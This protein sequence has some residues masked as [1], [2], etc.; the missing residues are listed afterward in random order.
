ML[1]MVSCVIVH[2]MVLYQQLSSQCYF[3]SFLDYRAK[4][5]WLWYWS[6]SPAEYR[7]LL[8]EEEWN[9]IGKNHTDHICKVTGIFTSEGKNRWVE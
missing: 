9:R 1:D 7:E 4:L 3:R 8:N 6:R 2:R 5:L